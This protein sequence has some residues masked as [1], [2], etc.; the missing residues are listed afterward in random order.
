[1]IPFGLGKQLAKPEGRFQPFKKWLSW[2][3]RMLRASRAM[4]K[5]VISGSAILGRVYCGPLLCRPVHEITTV[6]VAGVLSAVWREKPEVARKLYPA[7]R[8]VFEYA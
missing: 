4:P 7:I 3:L 8:R 5:F 2:S 1:L 6:D